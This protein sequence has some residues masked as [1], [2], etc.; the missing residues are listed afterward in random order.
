MRFIP[1]TR[2][3]MLWRFG[4]GALIVI[5]FTA[6]ATA[7]AG[8]LQFNEFAKDLSLSKAIPHANVTIA[9]PGNPQTE[10]YVSGRFG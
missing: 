9:N 2:G 4:L 1:S 7:V 8:L 6:T 10:A 5:A 3:G